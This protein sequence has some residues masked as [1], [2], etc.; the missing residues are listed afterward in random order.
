MGQ[1]VIKT[2]DYCT[3]KGLQLQWEKDFAISVNT[4][5]NEV[6]I[7]ANKSGLISLARHLLTL[8]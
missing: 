2:L 4:P 8:A 1:Y 3:E 7:R 5:G 6:T